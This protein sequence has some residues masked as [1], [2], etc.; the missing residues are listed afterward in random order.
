MTK[1]SFAFGTYHHGAKNGELDRYATVLQDTLP[2]GSSI[3]V[4]RH[5]QGQYLLEADSTRGYYD[6]GFR[7]DDAKAAQIYMAVLRVSLRFGTAVQFQIVQ[8]GDGR[9]DVLWSERCGTP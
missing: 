8:T 1:G 2:D 5:G 6:G 3:L 9:T 4:T 7:G